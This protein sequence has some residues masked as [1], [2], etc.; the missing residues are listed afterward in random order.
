MSQDKSFENQIE[1]GKNK[2]TILGNKLIF[3]ANG[4]VLRPI[5]IY[6]INKDSSTKKIRNCL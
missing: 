4:I 1:T 6:K 5:N 3:K 2:F